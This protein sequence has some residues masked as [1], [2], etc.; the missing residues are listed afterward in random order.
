MLHHFD[1]QTFCVL[2]TDDRQWEE[3]RSYK[4]KNKQQTAH[5]NRVLYQSLHQR[6]PMTNDRPNLI[7][8]TNVQDGGIR[9]ESLGR[10]NYFG[11]VSFDHVKNVC[12][13]LNNTPSNIRKYQKCPKQFKIFKEW[14]FNKCRSLGPSATSV[15][16][17]SVWQEVTS[18]STG[19][20]NVVG[21]KNRNYMM[22]K[23]GYM[24]ISLTVTIHLNRSSNSSDCDE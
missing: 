9:A 21:N 18:S 14:P 16:H 10:S 11:L 17:W 3:E 6:W 23:H 13:M 19:C 2:D 22:R 8:T 24:A 4:V 1:N 7:R 20:N 15:L 12:I 5:Y